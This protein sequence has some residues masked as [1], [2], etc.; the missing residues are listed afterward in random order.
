[1]KPLAVW[2][3]AFDVMDRVEFLL[4]VGAKVLTVQV[5]NG[6]PCIW[7]MVDPSEQQKVPRQFRVAG[8]GHMLEQD[9]EFDE[10]QYIGTFQLDEG[11]FIG[12]LFETV[13]A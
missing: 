9:G 13:S 3:Y 10:L 12:H 7:V 1:M 6:R 4:P 5:Q 8:T 2:K 11:R